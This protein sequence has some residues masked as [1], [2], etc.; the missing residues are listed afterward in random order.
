MNHYYSQSTC[1][2]QGTSLGIICLIDTQ[3]FVI[4]ETISGLI[5]LARM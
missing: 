1:N 3:I 2:P 5:S 4:I